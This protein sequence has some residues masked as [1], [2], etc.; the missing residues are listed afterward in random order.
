METPDV[1]AFSTAEALRF[2]WKKTKANL[3]PL[4]ILGAVGAFLALLQG[5]LNSGR[6]GTGALLGLV[7]QLAQVG[8]TMAWVRVALWAYDGEKVR[9]PQASAL[10]PDFFSFLLASV[11][12]GLFVAVGL[13]MFIVPGVFWAATFCFFG[14]AVL[15]QGLD[16]IAALRE[17]HRL[18]VGARGQVL[19]FG[20]AA[21]GVNLL[22]ALALGLGLLVTVPTTFIAAGHVY[23][24]LLSRAASTAHPA[25]PR[26]P[27][28]GPQRP[29]ASH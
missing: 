26:T 5:Q 6:S 9:V 15:D 7:V 24:R 8:V 16:P 2:G 21:L 13:V 23:R 20:L 28:V 29:S 12:Y 18:T 10:L 14:F 17:S 25:P 3:G 1:P 22:G 4:L 11:L 19:A 27:F